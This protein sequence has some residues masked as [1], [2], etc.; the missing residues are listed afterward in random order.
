MNAVTALAK[1]LRPQDVENVIASWKMSNA[2]ANQLRWTFENIHLVQTEAEWKA[3]LV[4]GVPRDWILD[5][6]EVQATNYDTNSAADHLALRGR[7]REW[8]LPVFPVNG[9]DIID[10]GIKPGP[11]VG[12]ILTRM[13]EDWIMDN[14]ETGVDYY[15]GNINNFRD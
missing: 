2:E 11:E 5:L 4:R 15:L 6:F 10:R 14:Y 8:K 12:R 13:R 3:D 9:N 7:L 1:Y